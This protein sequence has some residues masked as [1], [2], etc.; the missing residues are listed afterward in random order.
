MAEEY[1]VDLDFAVGQF[2]AINCCKIKLREVLKSKN[3]IMWD[4]FDDKHVLMPKDSP[5]Y[6]NIV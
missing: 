3:Y 2:N 1:H 6:I 4:E 5:E